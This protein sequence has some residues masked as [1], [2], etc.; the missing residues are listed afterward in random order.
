[1]FHLRSISPGIEDN[2]CSF[3]I[4]M[5]VT[6]SGYLLQDLGARSV[7]LRRTWRV[8]VDYL[9]KLRELLLVEPRQE[10]ETK[11]KLAKPLAKIGDEVC[12]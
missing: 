4:S 1:M 3:L 12:Q 5:T 9:H 10:R 6:G 8:L 7:M 2:F 11:R